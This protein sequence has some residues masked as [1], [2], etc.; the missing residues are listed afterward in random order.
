M[1]LARRNSLEQI[2]Q[3]HSVDL[4]KVTEINTAKLTDFQDQMGYHFKD[5]WRLERA[6]THASVRVANRSRSHNQREVRNDYERL[7]FLGDR[8]LGL[9]IAELLWAADLM[10]T[11]GDLARRYNH[12]VR[13]QACAR[14]ARALNIGDYIIM[15]HAEEDNGGRRKGTILG[16]AC[17]ALLGAI[18]V[19]GGFEEARRFIRKHWAPLIDEMPSDAVDPKS[20][21]QEWAQAKG[22][23]LPRYRELA[24]SGPDHEPIFTAQVT[25]ED[26]PPA[27]GQGASKRAAEQ[28]AADAMLRRERNARRSRRKKNNDQQK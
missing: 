12:L 13:K 18:F 20:A 19:D 23:S 8:V 1:E 24:R 6:L 7:E 11:E 10:A 9:V 15:S 28:A 26:L 27:E 2:F 16:D 17:E 5:I 4:E 22:M 3:H 14:V 21:L 25:L